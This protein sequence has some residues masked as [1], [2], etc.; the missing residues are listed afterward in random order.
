MPILKLRSHHEARETAFELKYL[1]SLTTQQRFQ[2]ML[3]KSRELQQL[4]AR[5]GHR[6]TSQILK[7]AS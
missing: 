1:R 5:R 2:L 4:L 7:R 6:T 3:R